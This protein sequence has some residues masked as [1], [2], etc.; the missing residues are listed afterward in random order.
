MIGTALAL[1]SWMLRLLAP[2]G[3]PLRRGMGDNEGLAAAAEEVAEEVAAEAAAVG[4]RSLDGTAG[5]GS[6]GEAAG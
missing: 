1:S 3:S 6:A 5:L 2:S 4:A